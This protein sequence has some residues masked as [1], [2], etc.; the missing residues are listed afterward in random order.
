[1]AQDGLGWKQ[2]EKNDRSGSN[3]SVFHLL[4][5][6]ICVCAH[7]HMCMYVYMPQHMRGDQ[8]AAFRNQFSSSTR[9]VL[10]IEIMA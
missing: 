5:T 7:A 1:M 8:M 2:L 9:W 4:S 6:F 3:I 10:R